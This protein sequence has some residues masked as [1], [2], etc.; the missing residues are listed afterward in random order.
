MIFYAATLE[1]G[2][3]LGVLDIFILSRFGCWL[4]NWFCLLFVK[5][6]GIQADDRSSCRYKSSFQ[7]VFTLLE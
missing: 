7:H 5:F 1:N 3:T 4:G 6:Y 2:K